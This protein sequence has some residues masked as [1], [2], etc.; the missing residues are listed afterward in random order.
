[1]VSNK[2]FSPAMNDD[3]IILPE[4]IDIVAN[5]TYNLTSTL[6]ADCQ[7][8]VFSQIAETTDNFVVIIAIVA[9]ILDFMLLILF[10]DRLAAIRSRPT[11]TFFLLVVVADVV[12]WLNLAM[13][14]SLGI[15]WYFTETGTNLYFYT[16]C[17]TVVVFNVSMSLLQFSRV[18]DS[19][20]ISFGR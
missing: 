14:N 4:C 2:D 20:R 10:L 6:N 18:K 19:L 9:V 13:G 17:V 1:C 11:V 12:T 7:E 8:D 3:S 15:P 5:V 16:G